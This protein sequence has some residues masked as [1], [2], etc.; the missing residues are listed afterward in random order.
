MLDLTRDGHLATVLCGLV[1]V[2]AHRVTLANAG[3]LPPLVADGTGAGYPPVKPAAPIGI[4]QAAA[5]DAPEAAVVTVPARGLLIAYTDGL[6]ERRNEALDVG[7]KRLADAT[8]TTT[9]RQASTLDELLD[10]IITE[11]TGDRPSDDVA[12]IGL[13]WLT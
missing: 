4:P 8:T 10:S 9:T 5:R 2:A 6:I 11:L 12:L 3:H 13:K 1:E 7:M